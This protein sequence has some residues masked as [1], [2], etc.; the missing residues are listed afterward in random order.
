[1]KFDNHI[2][3]NSDDGKFDWAEDIGFNI[4]WMIIELVCGVQVYRDPSHA[5]CQPKAQVFWSKLHL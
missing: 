3:E 4:S 2:F 1:M 5:N